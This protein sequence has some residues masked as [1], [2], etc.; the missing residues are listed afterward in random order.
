M[1]NIDHSR[2]LKEITWTKNVFDKNNV[3]TI[4]AGSDLLTIKRHG[5]WKSSAV[6]EGYIETSMKSKVAVAHNLSGPST[7]GHSGVISS[8]DSQSQESTVRANNITQQN[9]VPKNLSLPLEPIT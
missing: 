6:A 4:D 2:A 3:N 9:F 5:V 1:E 7:S 8:Y